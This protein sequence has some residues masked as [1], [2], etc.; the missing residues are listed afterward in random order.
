MRASTFA[1]TCFWVGALAF[2]TML[3]M[4][5]VV[6]SAAQSSQL[7]R[8]NTEQREVNRFTTGTVMMQ[9]KRSLK[10]ATVTHT[11]DTHTSIGKHGSPA[12][13]RA[14]A[15]PGKSSTKEDYRG[16]V[17][18]NKANIHEYE[19]APG[20][21]DSWIS[22]ALQSLEAGGLPV[23]T[24]KQPSTKEL[25]FA[26]TSSL[27]LITLVALAWRNLGTHV[28]LSTEDM[29]EQTDRHGF[30]FGLFDTANCSLNVVFAACCCPCIMWP[31]TVS[32]PKLNLIGFWPAF[33]LMAVLIC[34]QGIAG[35]LLV[36]ALLGALVYFRQ[37]IRAHYSLDRGSCMSVLV[38]CLSWCF[39][40][41][42]AAAQE[43]KQVEYVKAKSQD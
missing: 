42:C 5:Y 11:A 20:K 38:D 29:E 1:L 12:E 35:G 40:P 13:Q 19:K 7:Q 43:W 21:H 23:D 8:S 39:C 33:F 37:A 14:S 10:T 41:C 15:S 32:N 17:L 25:L 9:V 6:P 31:T 26:G 28:P 36:L 16:K 4:M 3:S 2:A 22:L 18:E 34:Y 24:M 30:Q 27:I